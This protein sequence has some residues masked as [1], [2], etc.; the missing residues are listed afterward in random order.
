MT[1][2][3]L[4]FTLLSDA[5]FGRGEGIAGLIDREVEHDRYGLP[6]LRGRTLKGLITEETDNILYALKQSGAGTDR[7]VTA[8][9]SLFGQA[10]STT[11][12]RGLIRFGP[13]ELPQAVR[14]A[15]HQMHDAARE[16]AIQRMG[17]A[18]PD[19]KRRIVDTVMDANRRLVLESLTAVRRQTAIEADGVRAGVPAEG[20]L[21]AMRVI[22]RRTPFEARLQCDRELEPDELALLA[23]SVLAFRRAGTGRN[24]GRGKLTADLIDAGGNSILATHY[25]HFIDTAQAQN[26]Q[27]EVAS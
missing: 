9:Q 4:T 3:R 5:T 23:A 22:L 8:R 27:Q 17:D 7:W 24:R 21:R 6:Y 16:E 10:G 2:Y 14:D 25:R 12:D 1:E 13:A 20:S 19:D 18:N 15:V 11:A 26:L